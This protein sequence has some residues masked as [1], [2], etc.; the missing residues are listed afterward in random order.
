MHPKVRDLYKRFL[1]AGRHYPQGLPYVREKVK[2]AFRSAAAGQE[3]KGGGGEGV[4]VGGGELTEVQ[5]EKSFH[6]QEEEGTAIKKLSDEELNR[7]LA[8]G[9][10]WVREL[11]AITALHKYRQMKKRYGLGLELDAQPEDK[12]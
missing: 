5:N 12:R 3:G 6:L 10:Y 2:A 4:V 7:A 11:Q 8:K 1:I 9:R